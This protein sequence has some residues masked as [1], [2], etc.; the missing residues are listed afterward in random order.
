MPIP[1]NQKRNPK[2]PHVQKWTAYRKRKGVPKA[3]PTGE[4]LPARYRGLIRNYENRATKHLEERERRMGVY[5]ANDLR[6]MTIAGVEGKVLIREII[7]DFGRTKGLRVFNFGSGYGTELFFLR[8]Y[9]K[10]KT[11]GVELLE[12][13]SEVVKGKKLGI[14]FGKNATDPELRKQGEFDVTYSI[15]V[16]DKEAVSKNEAIGILENAFHMTRKGGISYHCINN[17]KSIRLTR[18]EIEKIGFKI[19]KWTTSS[20]VLL[21]KLSK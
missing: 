7:K 20:G 13:P 6:P 15:A 10:A 12:Y 1:K 4:T 8:K 2:A 17:P 3:K 16:L 11:R 9:A 19:K 14:Q 5:D 18:S 21:I